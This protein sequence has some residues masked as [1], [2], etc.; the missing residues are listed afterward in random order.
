VGEVLGEREVVARIRL[1]YWEKW[2]GQEWEAMAAIG[3]SF[4][5]AQGNYEV[6]MIPAG[7]WASSPDL[8]KFLNA[9]QQGIPPD[10]IGL[11]G[12]QIVDLAVKK[13]LTPLGELIEPAQLARTDYQQPFLELGKYSDELYGVPVSGDIVTLYVN[14]AAVQ[15][16]RFEMGR[17]P[18]DLGEFDAGLEELRAR[19]QVGFIPT[20]PGWWPQAWVWFFGGSWF[21]DRGRFTPALPANNRAYEWVSSFRRRWNLEAF[22]KPINPLGAREPDPFLEGEIA[23]VFEGDWLIQRLLQAPGVDWRPAPFPTVAQGPAALIVADVLSIPKGGRHQEGAAE[24]ILFAM[25]PEQIERLAL[26]QVKISPLQHWSERFL[27]QHQNPKLRVLREILSTAQL[28]HDPRVSGWMSYLE[29]I[30]QAFK[31]V[32]S[33]QE[34]PA[35]ALAAIQEPI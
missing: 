3:R 22:A 14:L 29:Q 34:T 19:G 15:G 5:E 30:K 21:D 7:D 28:F 4:N 18:I 24:F 13:A 11:E 9:Q 26:G 17:I 12:H 6:V 16:T 35:Q 33:G 10:L 20:Y 23:M 2:S 25:Q 8:P 32:W 31:R 1:E 27:A